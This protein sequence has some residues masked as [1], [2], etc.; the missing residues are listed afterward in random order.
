MANEVPGRVSES[1]GTRR[2]PT[3][4]QSS[5]ENRLSVPANLIAAY[6]ANA[7]LRGALALGGVKQKHVD[8]LQGLLEAAVAADDAQA[9]RDLQERGRAGA[10]DR[11]D[12][13]E[14]LGLPPG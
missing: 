1:R 7:D 12:F 9:M 3:Y 4:L 11:P 2:R 14:L 13:L 8:A 10:A 5:V 6:G